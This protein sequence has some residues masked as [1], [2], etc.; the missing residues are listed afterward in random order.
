M[1]RLLVAVVV[2]VIVMT[3]SAFGADDE[4]AASLTPAVAAAAT[5][6][7]Q[8]PDLAS[9]NLAVPFR[10][11]NRPFALP[12]LYA[13]SAFL[14]GYDAYSTLAAIRSGATEANPLMKG[15][16]KSPVAFVALKAGL[17]T[18]SI[19]SA[20]RLWKDNHRVAAIAMMAASNGMMAMVAAHNASV[21]RRVR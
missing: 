14:Q 3:A 18:A 5:S 19:M 11:P 13:G 2:G 16:T 9:I 7:A 10:A 20:E 21:L 15:I 4:T 12:A 17:T 1:R 8:R 6:L